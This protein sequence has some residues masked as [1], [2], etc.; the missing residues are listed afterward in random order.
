MHFEKIFF[1]FRTERNEF[2]SLMLMQ[3][4]VKLFSQTSLIFFFPR[5]Y[6]DEKADRKW[7]FLICL[8]KELIKN[9]IKFVYKMKRIIWFYKCLQRICPAYIKQ[10]LINPI[11]AILLTN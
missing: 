3:R 7:S 11:L 4:K 9:V 1:F 10:T 8:K 6:T 5:K 2:T